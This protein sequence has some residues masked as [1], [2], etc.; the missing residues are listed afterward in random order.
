MPIYEYTC[1]NCGH[2]LE[3]LQKMNEKPLKK[4]PQCKK[5]KLQKNISTGGFILKGGGWHRGGHSA[6]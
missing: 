6:G 2:E 5:P 1:A 4:C 3:V